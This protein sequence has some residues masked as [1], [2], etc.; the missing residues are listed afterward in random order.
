MWLFE[1]W[2]MSPSLTLT[3]SSSPARGSPVQMSIK[4]PQVLLLGEGTRDSFRWMHLLRELSLKAL[5]AVLVLPVRSPFQPSSFLRTPKL[6]V[7]GLGADLPSVPCPTLDYGTCCLCGSVG[8]RTQ[9]YLRPGCP[10]SASIPNSLPQ[11]S[12]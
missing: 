8:A 10:N 4:C 5:Y 2:L 12:P 6:G 7:S 9:S 1:I 3:P 11:L